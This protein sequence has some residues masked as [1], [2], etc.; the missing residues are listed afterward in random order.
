MRNWTRFVS[1][2]ESN[3]KQQIS[4]SLSPFSFAP[5]W[6]RKLRSLV[7]TQRCVNILL[8]FFK[9]IIIYWNERAT[10]EREDLLEHQQQWSLWE[11][12][13]AQIIC[14]YWP[15][16]RRRNS[17]NIDR[18]ID[19]DERRK[20]VLLSQMKSS[21]NWNCHGDSAFVAFGVANEKKCERSFSMIHMGVIDWIM[22]ATRM[23]LGSVLFIYIELWWSACWHRINEDVVQ[24]QSNWSDSAQRNIST[25]NEENLRNASMNVIPW[26]SASDR[27]AS[28]WRC[29]R[30]A[31]NDTTEVSFFSSNFKWKEDHRA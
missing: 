26:T 1:K 17:N 28:R 30:S 20:F 22:L 12:F 19:S 3:D 18:L 27:K 2:R 24:T 16:R 10:R 15:S 25:N 21:L 23:S 7:K 14:Q 8:E 4:L 29:N 13:I 5:R 31:A 6:R 9:Q 11:D